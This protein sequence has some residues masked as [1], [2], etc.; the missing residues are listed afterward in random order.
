MAR[1]VVPLTDPK[2]DAAKPREK[3]Y[4]LFDGKGLYLLVKPSGVKTWRMKYTKPDD[5]DG[6]ATF[7]NYPALGLKAARERRAQALGLPV[8]EAVQPLRRRISWNRVLTASIS[9]RSSSGCVTVRCCPA[10]CECART[11]RQHL[12]CKRCTSR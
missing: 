11:L 3:D 6:L 2:C 12:S 9:R 10:A 8:G 5:R 1:T 4:K 7:G